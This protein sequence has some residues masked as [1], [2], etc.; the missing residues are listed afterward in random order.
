LET[1]NYALIIVLVN[2]IVYFRTMHYGYVGDDVERSQR[3]R[4]KRYFKKWYHRWWVQFIGLRHTNPQHAH[5]MTIM[6]HTSVCVLI[7]FALGSNNVSFLTALLFSINPVN[8]QGSVWVSGRNYAIATFLTLLMFLSPFTSVVPYYLTTFF[9]VNAWFAP[10]AFLWTPH[11]YLFLLVP[12]FL[13]FSK[14]NKQTIH[15]KIWGGKIKTTNSEMREVKPDKLIIFTKTFGYYYKICLFPFVLGIDHKFLY[16]F[17]TNQTDNKKGYK[18]DG[19]FWF[20]LMCG[21]SPFIAFHFGLRE[22][23][24]GL[25]WFAVNIAMWSNFITI[26]Q[27][28]SLRY[29]YL[30]NVG[31]SYALANLIIGYPILITIFLVFYLTRLWYTLPSY[32]NDYWAVEYCIQ[33]TRTFH[34]IW[35]MRGVKKYFAKDFPGAYFDFMEAHMHKPYDFKVLYNIAATSLLLGNVK[36]AREFLERAKQNIYDE[37]KSEIVVPIRNIEQSIL[38]AEAQLKSGPN[39]NLDLRNV[40][41]VK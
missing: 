22:V 39:I 33:E 12:L 10:L 32:I 23:G 41:V 3:R 16:G 15:N 35:L 34:Y 19:H 14:R 21:L 40:L 25:W 8:I 9:S 18:I 1:I 36:Q 30:A 24:W 28:I 26:Q 4:P 11:W 20:G 29:V 5:F 2:L 27:Q 37:M 7:Y 6:V 38:N 31:M 13:I 17:G